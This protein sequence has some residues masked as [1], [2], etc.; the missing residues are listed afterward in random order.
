MEG[1]VI[2]IVHYVI[3][4]AIYRKSLP[5]NVQLGAQGITGSTM[6][7]FS[8]PAESAGRPRIDSFWE[9]RETSS[10]SLLFPI[11]VN[12]IP[13]PDRR[14]RRE[15][16]VHGRGAPFDFCELSL[17]STFYLADVRGIS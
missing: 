2:V 13:H 16:W 12:N 5:N 17:L 9:W 8:E 7:F 15:K 14:R 10:S 11:E 6:A 1:R 3:R 4:G